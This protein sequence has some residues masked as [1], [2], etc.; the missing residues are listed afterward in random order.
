MTNANDTKDDGVDHHH[1]PRNSLPSS[2]EVTAQRH[3]HARGD[4]DV[5]MLS[6]LQ[7]LQLELLQQRH[8]QS[9]HG[10]SLSFHSPSPMYY[11]GT[12]TNYGNVIDDG[13]GYDDSEADAVATR[14]LRLQNQYNDTN[15]ALSIIDQVFAII[16]S[17]D[18][19]LL[20][21][22]VPAPAPAPAPP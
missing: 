9:H 18:F 22:N 7:A 21:T 2:Q 15:Y 16:D 6:L 4:G 12:T 11:H 1:N 5:G 19:E 13:E 17:D 10:S 20:D 14:L 8:Q 3:A